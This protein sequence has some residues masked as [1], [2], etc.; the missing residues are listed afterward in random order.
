MVGGS[1][2]AYKLWKNSD[3]WPIG[4]CHLTVETFAEKPKEHMHE[5]ISTHSK[6]KSYPHTQV[7]SIYINIYIYVWELG[8][9]PETKASC[10]NGT[11]S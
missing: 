6:H 3:G 10:V 5:I 8:P 11:I 9:D 2:E 7:Y 4:F 1:K